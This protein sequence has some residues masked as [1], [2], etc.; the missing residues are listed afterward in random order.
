MAVLKPMEIVPG[1][2]SQTPSGSICLE[3]T[4]EVTVNQDRIQR[5]PKSHL[6]VVMLPICALSQTLGEATPSVEK[7]YSDYLWYKSSPGPHKFGGSQIG[8]EAPW[9]LSYAQHLHE[10]WISTAHVRETGLI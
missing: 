7:L 9:G 6:C 8:T 4:F 2:L 5:I 1:L 10:S 3:D